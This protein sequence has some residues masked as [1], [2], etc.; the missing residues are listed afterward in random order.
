MCNRVTLLFVIPLMA[1]LNCGRFSIDE[2]KRIELPGL[3][4]GDFGSEGDAEGDGSGG[5]GSGGGQSGVTR[6]LWKGSAENVAL[7]GYSIPVY[8][9]AEVDADG[10]TYP[11]RLTGRGVLQKRVL[12][13]DIDVYYAASFVVD[14]H[15]PLQ[16]EPMSS[17]SQSPVELMQLTF[18]RTVSGDAAR[19]AILEAL[20]ANGVDT[21]RADIQVIL[22]RFG[23]GLTAGESLLLVTFRPEG[24]TVETLI[25]AGSS[26]NATVQG[27]NL[28]ISLWRA[29]FGIP[30]DTGL[31]ALKERLRGR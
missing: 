1:C 13:L 21:E 2:L 14:A 4:S 22:N 24:S 10:E 17:I 18:V 28:G 30:A 6:L 7:G 31:A 11:L 26:G 12:F 23:D 27:E 29:W 3:Q 5:E 25:M 15:I 8:P 20:K 16:E 9:A 19:G